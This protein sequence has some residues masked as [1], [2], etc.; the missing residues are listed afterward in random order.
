M[1]DVNGTLFFT[2]K[3]GTHGEE[4]WVVQKEQ[5]DVP[6][7]NGGVSPGSSSGGGGGG[8]CFISAIGLD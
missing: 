2:A 3:D 6:V 1:V 8:G 4:L 7:G 5:D